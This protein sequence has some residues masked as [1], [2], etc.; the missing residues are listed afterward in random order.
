MALKTLQDRAKTIQ[1]QPRQVVL[2]TATATPRKQTGSGN[3]SKDKA[4]AGGSITPG[5]G[6]CDTPGSISD[7]TKSLEASDEKARKGSGWLGRL[8]N[9]DDDG[10]SSSTSQEAQEV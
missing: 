1:E 2:Q 6:E 7:S 8:W 4:F 9:S 10:A 3:G 5:S